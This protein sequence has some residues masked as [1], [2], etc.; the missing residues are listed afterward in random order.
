[1][2]PWYPSRMSRQPQART[3][4]PL[5]VSDGVNQDRGSCDSTLRRAA[6]ATPVPPKPMCLKRA[7]DSASE[8]IV[9][10]PSNVVSRLPSS[11]KEGSTV[12][13]SF[14]SHASEQS[15]VQAGISVGSAGTGRPISAAIADAPLRDL[16]MRA[17][18]R[19]SLADRFDYVDTGSR[20]APPVASNTASASPHASVLNDTGRSAPSI[21]TLSHTTPGATTGLSA[22]G[23]SS[24]SDVRLR[25]LGSY[26]DSLRETARAATIQQSA[27]IEAYR[28]GSDV[29]HVK[30]MRRSSRNDASPAASRSVGLQTTL[31]RYVRFR[32]CPHG[33]ADLCSRYLRAGTGS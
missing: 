33:G 12:K 26:L 4:G 15:T 5:V 22:T 20:S 7:R 3:D 6:I 23:R 29:R 10:A 24:E 19:K 30:E 21:P 31:N 2:F 25:P 13:G 27:A 28:A 16:P 17:R 9:Q 32:Y 14:L 18:A 8:Q 11:R 1:M